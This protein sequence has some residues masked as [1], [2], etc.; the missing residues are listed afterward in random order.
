MIGSWRRYISEN[1][2][3]V[4]AGRQVISG[5]MGTLQAS[6]VLAILFNF[7]TRTRLATKDIKLDTL[8]LF[9][10]LSVPRTDCN[11]PKKNWLLVLLAVGLGHGPAALWASAVT[12]IQ[13]SHTIDRGSILLPNFN[14]ASG[15]VGPQTFE[16]GLV[17][18]RCRSNPTLGGVSNCPI[19]Y[20]Q[21]AL[22]NTAREATTS[23][24]APRNR[25]K[26]DTPS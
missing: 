22:L 12:P 13:V 14:E 10:A 11:L 17:L 15:D 8:G 5:I 16:G 25:S 20:F 3:A 7:P 1:P 24:G 18:S 19:P 6:A 26:L 21:N 4:S 9:N 23:N 2:S